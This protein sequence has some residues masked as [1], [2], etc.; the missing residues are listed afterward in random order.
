MSLYK[1][2]TEHLRLYAALVPW[3]AW[4]KAS[5]VLAPAGP[6]PM[7]ATRSLRPSSDCLEGLR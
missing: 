3:G 4:A 2:C 5:A 6:P 1:S 7:T